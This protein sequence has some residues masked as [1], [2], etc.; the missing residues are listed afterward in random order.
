MLGILLLGAGT[1]LGVNR[2]LYWT[3][4]RKNRM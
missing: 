1:H 3:K 2:L 4:L